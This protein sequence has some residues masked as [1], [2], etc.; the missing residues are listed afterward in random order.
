MAALK[1]QMPDADYSTLEHDLAE[2]A[3]AMRQAV[4]Q[5]VLGADE[6]GVS[7]E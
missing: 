1:Q 7:G 3:D 2:D 4:V 5:E 6:D